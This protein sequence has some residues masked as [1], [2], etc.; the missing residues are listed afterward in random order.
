MSYTV[1]KGDTL[2]SIAA[3]YHVSLASLEG[4]NKQIKNPNSIYVGEHIN[5]PGQKD[6]FSPPKSSKPAPKPASSGSTYTVRSG[7]TMSKIASSHG[8]SLS[9]LEKANP[10][11]H[12]FNV[13]SVGEKLH[14]PGKGSSSSG[15]THA[16]HSGGGT[17]KGTNAASLAKNYLGKYESQLQAEGVTQHCPWSESCANFVT[18]ML[19]KTGATNFRTL[20]VADLN[21]K[22]RARGWHVVPASQAKPGDVWI[23]NG[24]HG[25][26]H[27]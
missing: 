14:I 18:S 1:K 21:A 20:G 11:I 7:D 26:S 17:A 8:V 19:Y 2:S 5:I 23:C 3:R 22:L 15:G 25:E 6:S 16:V 4:A 24:A 12:N 10:Q 9:A 13:I 27:T